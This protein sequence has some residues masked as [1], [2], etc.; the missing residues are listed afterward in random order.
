LYWHPVEIILV[1]NI[2]NAGSSNKPLPVEP[3][4]CSRVDRLLAISQPLVQLFRFERPTWSDE[5]GTS[6]SRRHRRPKAIW[7]NCSLFLG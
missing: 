1:M 3:L 7:G 5:E 2:T 4:R 6:E